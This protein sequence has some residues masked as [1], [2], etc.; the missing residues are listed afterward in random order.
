MPVTK[1]EKEPQSCLSTYLY[2]ISGDKLL[3]AEEEKK[4]S[5]RVLGG[6]EEARRI[7]INSNLRL[8]VKIAKGYLTH[9]MEL[10]DLIQEGNVGLIKAA[11]KFDFKKNVRFSTY[12]SF[13]I[14]QSI[15]RAISNKSRMIRF[16][17]RKE[18]RLRRITK[19]QQRLT[20]S[21][22]RDPDL[23]ELA[24]ETKI[25]EQD[26]RSI[27]SLP[28]RVVSVESTGELD[29]FSLRSV[30]DDHKYDPDYIVMR[31][32]LKEKTRQMLNI[33]NVR[34]KKVLLLRYSF[35]QGERY[36]LKEIGKKLE[37]SPETVRQI[38][39]RALRKIREHFQHLRE[40]LV[41]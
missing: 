5:K 6:D 2:Q 33:L 30:I 24:G 41:S 17:H 12:A 23:K 39:M 21:L 18:E 35:L 37:I 15:A 28:N 34:E 38:E 9:D 29:A 26:V 1:T 19:A 10:L 32:Y 20:E 25:D 36:T 11:E 13:W 16:P 27:L 7:L 31:N 3:S 8:V 14:R 4:L 22:G 40:F